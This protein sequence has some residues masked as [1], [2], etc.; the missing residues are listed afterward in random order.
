M[1]KNSKYF[2]FT[3]KFVVKKFFVLSILWYIKTMRE[4]KI[5]SK[6]TREVLK[7]LLTVLGVAVIGFVGG[8][9]FKTFFESQDI[10]PTGMSGFALIIHNLIFQAG[11]N[12]PT[13]II[14]LVLNAIV[15]LLALKS[16]GWKFLVLSGVGMGAYTLAMQFGLISAIIA[17][18]DK[19]LFAIVG[20]L[21]SGLCVGLALRLGGSTGGSDV[22]GALVNHKFPKIKTGYCIL[23]FNILVL[24]LSVATSGI[25]T[26]LYA[27]LVSLISSLATNFVLDSAK[28]VV[29]YHIVC[30]K[31]DEIAQAIMT[32]YH[33]GVTEIDVRGAYSL[34]DKKMLLVLIPS[35][36][37]VEMKKLISSIDEKAFVFSSLVTE[38]IGQGNFLKEKSVL[39]NRI[40]LLDSP[41]LKTK[42]KYIRKDKIKYL[43]LKRKQKTLKMSKD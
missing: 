41:L 31:G 14:Y 42:T 17:T 38:T 2:L 16:F 8:C 5:K 7:F 34:T 3:T 23:G 18:P 1:P 30:D 19:L 33:R 43:R 32:K 20:G 40:T 27:V 24:I 36:Q 35:S 25:Q 28:S 10:I 39:Q 4:E 13:A 15:F 22:L 12:I 26:G 11:L 37:A 29:A 9:A 21:L 6:Q